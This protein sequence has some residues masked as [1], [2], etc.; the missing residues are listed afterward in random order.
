MK[1]LYFGFGTYRIR[2]KN[3]KYI[4]ALTYAPERG[5]RLVDIST[6]YA[7]GDAERAV[8]LALTTRCH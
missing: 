3:P 7:G 6:N 2:V 8:A 4:E 1:D 5:I